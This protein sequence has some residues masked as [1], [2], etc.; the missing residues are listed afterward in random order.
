MN[1][2][3]TLNKPDG[4]TVTI[5]IEQILL[6][7]AR[8]YRIHQTESPTWGTYIILKTNVDRVVTEA[9]SEVHEKIINYYQSKG[10]E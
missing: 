6:F 7:E 5:N 8:E 4:T 3:I 1:P 9:Y 2:Y 10:G